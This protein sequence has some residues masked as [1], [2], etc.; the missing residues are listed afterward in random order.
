M[1]NNK[2]IKLQIMNKL[3]MFVFPSVIVILS[4]M[5]IGLNKPGKQNTPAANGF[6]VLELFTAEGC[7]SCPPADE[8]MIQLAKDY[9]ENV[10]ILGFH[11]DYWNYIGWTDPFS[12]EAF[13]E[14]QKS[15]A[16]KLNTKGVYTPQLIINGNKQFVGSNKSQVNLAIRAELDKNTNTAISLS[17]N[18]ESDDRIQVKYTTKGDRESVLR[19][20]V[21][22][23]ALIQLE[24]TTNVKRG[25]NEGRLLH[26]INIVR[27]LKT[28]PAKRNTNGTV[29]FAI[30][31][32]LTVKEVE[33]IAFLQNKND[34]QITG[35]TGTPVQ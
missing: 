30:P 18:K 31:P 7:S 21:L 24:A 4:C 35:A 25:E 17:A 23:I 29:T 8:A 28:I 3:S 10:Y 5:I 22:N 14:R 1:K 16:D 6:V 19:E 15:Y 13:S 9:P 33:L 26:H 34:W 11:V 27:E 12:S 32:G 2:I 20:S